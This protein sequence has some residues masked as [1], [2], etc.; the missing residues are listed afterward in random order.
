MSIL[1]RLPFVFGLFSLLRSS[2]FWL[3][4]HRN[5][6]SCSIQRQEN[7]RPTVINFRSALVVPSALVC[8]KTR[9]RIQE[10]I[11]GQLRLSLALEGLGRVFA[12]HFPLSW[13]FVLCP[14]FYP[15]FLFSSPCFVV[16]GSTFTSFCVYTLHCRLSS[17]S[18]GLGLLELTGE[19]DAK[20]VKTT[21]TKIVPES[22]LLCKTGKNWRRHYLVI[23]WKFSGE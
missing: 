12:S 17:S 4:C 2:P 5:S 22:T 10:R 16:D 6:E 13:R 19:C 21:A 15:R 14:H 1:W 7:G 20:K 11:M 9:T 8:W 23:W 18:D 3:F